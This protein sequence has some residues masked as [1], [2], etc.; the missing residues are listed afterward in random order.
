MT[1]VSALLSFVLSL[2]HSGFEGATSDR[3]KP[4]LRTMAGELRHS[5]SLF[6]FF[7]SEGISVS[8]E[9]FEGKV[10]IIRTELTNQMTSLS[11]EYQATLES[12]INL[13]IDL[14][15]LSTQFLKVSTHLQESIFTTIRYISRLEFSEVRQNAG[16]KRGHRS[17]RQQL[18]WSDLERVAKTLVSSFSSLV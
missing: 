5:F 16:P 18:E 6:D 17:E 2:G 15:G 7:D 11:Y 12:T 9:K 3:V 8:R 4:S 14:G 13:N 10:N 1:S